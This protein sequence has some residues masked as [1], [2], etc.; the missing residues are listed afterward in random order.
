MKHYFLRITLL[1]MLLR[2]KYPEVKE[3]CQ[4]RTTDF[5]LI[6][7]VRIFRLKENQ[8]LSLHFYLSFQT[9]IFIILWTLF[10]DDQ[11]SNVKMKIL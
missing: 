1:V 10:K 8:F 7:S 5:K 2:G 3:N 9:G 11:L 4:S 6:T